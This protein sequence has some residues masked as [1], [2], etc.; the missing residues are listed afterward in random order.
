MSN[1]NAS[2]LRKIKDIRR[3]DVP[4]GLWDID[5][6]FNIE[7]NDF[8]ARISAALADLFS[9]GPNATDLDYQGGGGG[10]LAR[11]INYP[12]S[13][14]DAYRTSIEQVFLEHGFGVV[15]ARVQWTSP[16]QNQLAIVIRCDGQDINLTINPS[17]PEVNS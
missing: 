1:Q 9:G 4:G 8:Q 7:N 10:G 3:I 16:A 15:K 13:D 5:P 14:L 6:V 17:A 12:L 11:I 2:S